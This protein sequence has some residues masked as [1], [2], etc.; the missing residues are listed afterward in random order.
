MKKNTGA[1]ILP[2]WLWATQRNRSR[3]VGWTHKACHDRPPPSAGHRWTLERTSQR[4]SHSHYRLNRWRTEIRKALFA[5]SPW[6]RSSSSGISGNILRNVFLW[7]SNLCELKR[8]INTR[9]WSHVCLF[10]LNPLFC[11]TIMHRCN[12]RKTFLPLK[13]LKWLSKVLTTPRS[14][15]QSSTHTDKHVHLYCIVRCSGQNGMLNE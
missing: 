14:W 10:R 6:V 12:Q 1:L 5:D 11:F 9:F 3:C 2:W 4:I 8:C 7:F 15:Y 13:W